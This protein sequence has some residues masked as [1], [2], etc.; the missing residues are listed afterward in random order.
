MVF[1]G[2][3][4]LRFFEYIAKCISLDRFFCVDF[5]ALANGFKIVQDHDFWLV[6]VVRAG[7]FLKFLAIHVL[8]SSFIYQLW[9]HLDAFF[10][11][12]YHSLIYLKQINQIIDLRS[13]LLF[14]PLSLLRNFKLVLLSVGD[15]HS[16]HISSTFLYIVFGLLT[17]F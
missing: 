2:R 17:F 14:R 11:K 4:S 15:L 9:I 8:Y 13:L 16:L 12:R 3:S 5:C 7:G 10:G 1:G 6:L